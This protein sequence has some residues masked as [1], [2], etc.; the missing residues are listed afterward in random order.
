V[1]LLELLRIHP[2]IIVVVVAVVAVVHHI[3]HSSETTHVVGAVGKIHGIL[4]PALLL[5]TSTELSIVPGGILAANAAK[6]TH[7]STAT[8]EVEIVGAPTHL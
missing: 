6:G 4:L 5:L 8:P 3:V 1:L 2:A 7:A